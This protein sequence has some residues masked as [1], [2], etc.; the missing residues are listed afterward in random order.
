MGSGG[1]SENLADF[2]EVVLPNRTSQDRPANLDPATE[3]WQHLFIPCGLRYLSKTAAGQ[4][5]LRFGLRAAC[6]LPQAGVQD[7]AA[8]FEAPF[9]LETAL[10]NEGAPV[11]RFTSPW[12]A[13]I[14]AS[15]IRWHRVVENAA[16]VFKRD[17]LA[18]KIS[19][20]NGVV[21]YRHSSK[22]NLCAFSLGE[23]G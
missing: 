1:F 14:D 12:D 20:F 16:I 3:F 10:D 19:F 11:V 22:G 18:G 7:E 6:G 23:R 5:R 4:F 17:P 13:E 8:L 21:E 2:G 9:V 15:E